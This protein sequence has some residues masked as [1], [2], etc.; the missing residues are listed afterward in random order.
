V[1][2]IARA[3]ASLVS[4]A[5]H[6]KARDRADVAQVMAVHTM[7]DSINEAKASLEPNNIVQTA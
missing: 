3:Y 7:D 4:R 6:I 5:N 1:V 2:C